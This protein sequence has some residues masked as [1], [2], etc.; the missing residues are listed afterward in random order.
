M[1][2]WLDVTFTGPATWG[3]VI[4]GGAEKTLIVST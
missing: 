1:T 2:Q 4:V 3:V